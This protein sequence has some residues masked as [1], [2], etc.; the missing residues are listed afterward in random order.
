MAT[1]RPQALRAALLPAVLSTKQPRTGL[2]QEELVNGA[3]GSLDEAHLITAVQ[4]HHIT[5]ALDVLSAE[6][7]RAVYIAAINDDTLAPR[8]RT[9]AIGE[10]VAGTDPLAPDLQAALVT[11][12]KAKDC[13]VA[14]AAA[15][16]L[17][18]RGDHRFAPRRP[19]TPAGPQVA[20]LMRSMCV[21]ASFEALQRSDEP[22]LLPTYLPSR[23]LERVVI[24]YD[25][26]S[27]TDS[28]GN[29][30]PHT[31]QTAELVP[32]ADAV[33]PEI[34]DLARAMQHCTGA[35]CVSDDHEFRFVWRPFGGELL[36]SRI[37]IADRPPCAARKAAKP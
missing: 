10:L 37:E 22:S 36:L 16:A 29:G 24:S 3:V 5:G 35:I 4:R 32:R 34:E 11:A 30:D 17:D 13:S 2:S 31:T 9:M 25:P 15:R 21:L 18:A 20:G 19:R 12:T 33:L 27:D 26:L 23:G 28:D 6:G 7:H 14:A 8:A 1:S